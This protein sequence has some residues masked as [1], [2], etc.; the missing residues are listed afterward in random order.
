MNNAE[1]AALG[2]ALSLVIQKVKSSLTY[3]MAD[4]YKSKHNNRK[5]KKRKPKIKLLNNGKR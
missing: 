4:V 5:K 1:S 3:S 2:I